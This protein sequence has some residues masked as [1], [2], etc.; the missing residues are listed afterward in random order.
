MDATEPENDALA[1]K[2]TYFGPGNQYRL[3][4]PLFVSQSVYEGQRATNP[5]KR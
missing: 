1:G 4:Y 5:A 3:T 2:Q